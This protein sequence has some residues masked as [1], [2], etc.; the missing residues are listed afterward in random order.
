MRPVWAPNL[1]HDGDNLSGY[2]ESPAVVVPG[3][4]VG[5]RGKLFFRLVQHAVNIEPVPYARIVQAQKATTTG[6]AT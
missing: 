5:S 3:D 1:G 6:R 2:P 4:V